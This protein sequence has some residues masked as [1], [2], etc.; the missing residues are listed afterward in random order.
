MSVATLYRLYPFLFWTIVIISC[1]WDPEIY[2]IYPRIIFPYRSLLEKT[3][4][5]RILTLEPIQVGVLLCYWPLTVE[6]QSYDPS[7]NYCGLI[8]NA[9]IK[10]GIHKGEI[11]RPQ[12]L[13]ETDDRIQ[14]K[15]W[16]ACFF[17]NCR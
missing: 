6:K 11:R 1:R 12:T 5:G 14:L 13:I 16:L 7:W 2:E 15:T 3:L 9:A 4:M 10:I 17:M 8:T